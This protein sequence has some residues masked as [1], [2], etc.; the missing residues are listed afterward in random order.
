MSSRRDFLMAST[1]GSLFAARGWAAKTNGSSFPYE[2]FEARIARRDFRD[3]TKDVLPTPSMVVDL[4]LFQSNLQRMADQV[5]VSGIQLRPHVKVHKS[6]DVAKRQIAQGAIGLTCATIAEAELFSGAGVKNVLWTKQ[7]AS[8]NNIQRTVALSRKDP[9]F[10]FVVDDPQVLDWVEEA[11]AVRNARLRIAVSVYAGMDRQGIENG[12]P[13]VELAQKVTASKRAKFEGFMAYSGTASHTK[14]W[15]ARKKR[16]Y[17][18]LAGV[19]E[20]VALARKAGLPVNIVSGG[21]TGTYNIDHEHGLTELE[22]GSYVFMDTAYL[23]VGSKDD[24]KVYNDFK[25]AL[26][27]LTTVDSKRHPNIATTDYGNKA[28]VRPTDQVK[29]MPWLQVGT[30]GAEYGSLRWTDTDKDVK[31][32]DRVEIYCTNLDMSTN[33]FDRYYV[34]KGDQIVDVWPIMGRMGPAQR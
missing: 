34:A 5:K 28:M 10:M 3:I 21:S 25:G 9:T 20:T 1:A 26:T 27:V 2:E 11:A 19:R 17:D 22:A 7:P 29:G 33:A 30:Q 16:S 6:V 8:H 24:D 4:D 31:L 32:G 15:G 13:A 12:Q 23:A 14:T 18:D